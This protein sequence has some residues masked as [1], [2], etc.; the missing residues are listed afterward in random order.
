MWPFYVLGLLAAC[1]LGWAIT[2][3]L[4]GRR[5]KQLERTNE[6]IQVEETLVFDFLHGLGA[7]FTETIR[8]ADLHRLIVEGAARILDANGGALYII[9]RG[10]TT[11]APAFISKGC[12]PLSEV[13]QEI[14]QQA[15]A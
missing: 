8:P 5:I 11:L 9:E 1:L 12:P 14:L 3:L 13:P 15:S 6:E 4:Q 10:G 7:A 2:G